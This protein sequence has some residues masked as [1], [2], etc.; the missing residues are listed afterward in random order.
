MAAMLL[1][2]RRTRQRKTFLRE[3]AG[4][5]P[6]DATVPSELSDHFSF[7]V[8]RVFTATRRLR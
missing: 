6:C 3:Q 8:E 5:A 7:G 1:R 4:C 2:Q